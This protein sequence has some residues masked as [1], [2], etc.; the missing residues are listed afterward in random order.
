MLLGHYDDDISFTGPRFQWLNKFNAQASFSHYYDN[1]EWPFLWNLETKARW[2][3]LRWRFVVPYLQGGV[4]WL[5]AYR[6]VGDA[7]EYYVEPGL[8]LHGT[9]DLAFFYRFQHQETLFS[10]RGPTENMN[11]VGVRALF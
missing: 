2:D 4:E 3:V 5:A 1:Q 11:F 9:M 10:F 8:R 7:V 6:G